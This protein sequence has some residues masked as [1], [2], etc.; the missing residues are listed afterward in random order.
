M[1]FFDYSTADWILRIG[2]FATSFGL[3]LVCYLGSFLCNDV[4]GCP[5]PSILHPSILTLEKLKKEAGWPEDGILGLGSFKVTG[6]VLAYYF[7]SLV[8]QT[9]LP[10]EESQ[11]VVLT[12]GGRLKYKFN[13]NLVDSINRQ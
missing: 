12:S 10:G 2:A 9:I 4:A 8:L 7:S 3:P 5:I 1:N 13:G 11:G 6:F